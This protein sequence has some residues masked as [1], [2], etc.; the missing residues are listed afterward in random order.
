MWG[1]PPSAVQP[2]SGGMTLQPRSSAAPHLFARHSVSSVVK[3]VELPSLRH[4]M[5]LQAGPPPWRGERN[6]PPTTPLFRS[7]IIN[8][9]STIHEPRSHRRTV[10]IIPGLGERPTTNVQRPPQYIDVHRYT[11]PLECPHQPQRHPG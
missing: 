2:R 6:P 3:D 9:Q 8:L 1:Q 10:G 4:I 11:S 7:S 5:L